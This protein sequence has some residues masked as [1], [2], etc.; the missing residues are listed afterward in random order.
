MDYYATLEVERTATGAEI[1]SAYRKLAMK[2]HPDRN[3]GD[4]ASEDRFKE[5]NEAY[6]CLS[7]SAKRAYYDR[8]GTAGPGP[9]PGGG[10][11]GDFG[12]VFGD[13]FENF[14]GGTFGGAGSARARGHD[15][16]Y[17]LE[18]TL[19]EA[20]AG[21]EQVLDIMR[22][23]NCEPCDGTGSKSKSPTTCK[24]CGGKGQVRFQ[25]GFFSIAKTCPKCEGEGR[26]VTDPCE[27]CSGS[28]RNRNTGKV[29]VKLPPGVDT[30]SRLKMTGDGEPGLRGGPPGDLYIII[31]VEEHEFLQRDGSDLYCEVPLSFADAALGTE[32]MVPTL[33]GE[34]KLKIPS[35]TQPGQ[36]FTLR[37]KG[38]TR[39]GSRFKGDQIVVVR[40]VV[41]KKLG[42]KQ[43]ELLKEFSSLGKDDVLDS[44]KEKIKGLFS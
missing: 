41:P 18:I 7:D 19:G 11:A 6:S 1:K 13:I 35:G 10:P 3:P 39:L 26:V 21:C 32:F 12:D 29:S 2:C 17:D 33:D 14:F 16:R 42:R 44:F 23:Q 5:V 37:G 15:L 28:G 40:V 25:Q 31:H 38:I 4:K 20:A 22:W 24:T 27:T 8:F 43:K 34:Q 36:A 9:G 30:G